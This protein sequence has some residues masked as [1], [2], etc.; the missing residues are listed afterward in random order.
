MLAA[1]TRNAPADS[2]LIM[3]RIPMFWACPLVLT[4][5]PPASKLAPLNPYQK[6][7]DR[8]EMITVDASIPAYLRSRRCNGEYPLAGNMQTKGSLCT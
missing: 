7:K 6:W 5:V 8:P 3:V 4:R 1:L 2:L